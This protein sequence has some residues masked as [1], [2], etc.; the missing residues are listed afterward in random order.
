[1]LPEAPSEIERI[2]NKLLRKDRNERYQTVKDV[3]IDL[4]DIR[5]E[6]E[7]QDK[8]KVTPSREKPTRESPGITSGA[9]AQTTSS[10]EYIVSEIK[11]RKTGFVTALAVCC[12]P[13]LGFCIPTSRSLTPRALST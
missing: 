4:K 1:L 13:L 8:L 5:K 3:L 6:L 7:F 2:I 12:S 11:K 10:A 9:K